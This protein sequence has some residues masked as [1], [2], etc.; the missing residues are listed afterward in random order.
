MIDASDFLDAKLAA[1]RAHASQIA[2]D[3]QFFALSNGVVLDSWAGHED[4]PPYH[5]WIIG[6]DATSLAPICV[7]AVCPD[8]YAGG[9]WQGGRAPTIDAAGNAYFAPGNGRQRP[10]RCARFLTARARG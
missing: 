8:S 10:A 2:V 4:R 3:S 6:Y 1:M 5:G 9:I 7:F